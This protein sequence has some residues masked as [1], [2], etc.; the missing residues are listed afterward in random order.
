MSGSEV[1]DTTTIWYGDTADRPLGQITLGFAIAIET[2]R[3]F[4]SS[5]FATAIE[6]LASCPAKTAM[7]A[8]LF[9]ST[10]GG[11]PGALTDFQS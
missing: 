6:A 1:A 10:F 7:T 5:I 4:E 9:K 11:F 2:M 3:V 8:C